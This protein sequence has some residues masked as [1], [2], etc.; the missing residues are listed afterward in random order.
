MP[1][2][3]TKL[4]SNIDWFDYQLD[5][6]Q[7]AGNRVCLY[8]RT[9]AGKTLTGLGILTVQGYTTALVIAPPATHQQWIQAASA[10]GMSV[11]CVS[12]AKFRMNDFK[13]SR[14]QPVIADEF[15]L[16]GGHKGRGWK[17]FSRLAQGIQATIVIMSATP[18]YNDAERVYCIQK[19]LDPIGVKGGYLDFL[20]KN[21]RVSHNPFSMEPNVDGFL[22][23]PDA[24][25][26]LAAL[27]QV[28]YVPDESKVEPID[29][30]FQIPLPKFFEDYGLD[31]L[32][33]RIVASDMEKRQ[34]R[35][36]MQRVQLNP[37]P[38]EEAPYCLVKEVGETLCNYQHFAKK[39]IVFCVRETIARIVAQ[40]MNER[41]HYSVLITGNT[42]KATRDQLLEE[43]KTDPEVEFLVCTAT[44]ATGVDGLDKVCD[45]LV[46]FDDTPDA[47]L[48]RQIIGRILP[49]GADVDESKKEVLRYVFV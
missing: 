46:L 28:F 15:H 4:P 21:C 33:G 11:H 48:R 26:Y 10:F 49:R 42:K 14:T 38:T 1:S 27:P 30:A 6:F 32:K 3:L 35:S 36:F 5:A 43:F 47:S 9:G 44:I 17:K 2:E 45:S 16:F 12:H 41:G 18:N 22:N 39:V 13:L 23:H 29:V 25:S 7:N 31:Q 37:Y 34:R 19:I 20:Y 40:D 24:K 8:Y